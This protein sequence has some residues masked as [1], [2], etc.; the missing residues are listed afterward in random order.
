MDEAEEV[1]HESSDEYTV[2]HSAQPV[3]VPCRW[4]PGHES[5]GWLSAHAR[6]LNNGK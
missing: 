3:T 5:N 4:P 2:H 1:L 6:R